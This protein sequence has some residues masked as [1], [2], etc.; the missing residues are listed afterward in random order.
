MIYLSKVDNHIRYFT[1]YS[2]V[3]TTRFASINRSIFSALGRSFG[4]E[5]NPR[6]FLHCCELAMIKRGTKIASTI[7]G[8]FTIVIKPFYLSIW[9]VEA[10]VD[11]DYL[12]MQT[13]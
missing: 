2:V 8:L 4:E 3:T 13:N 5:S 1:D 7:R 6:Y 12:N 11:C 10:T 9:A